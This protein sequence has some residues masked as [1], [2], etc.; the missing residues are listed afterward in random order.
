VT[1]SLA[2]RRK[3]TEERNL[4]LYL[5]GGSP[6]KDIDKAKDAG[7]MDIKAEAQAKCDT[8]L[9]RKKGS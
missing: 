8:R 7:T 2:S 6:Q 1:I 3:A 9:G 5:I 4:T